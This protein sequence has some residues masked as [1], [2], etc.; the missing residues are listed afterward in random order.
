[1]DEITFL[2]EEAPVGG[3]TAQALW[4]SIFAEADDLKSLHEQIRD[5]V[6]CHFEEERAP[7]VVRLH[8]ADGR[9]VPLSAGPLPG[10]GMWADRKDMEDSADWVNKQRDAWQKR[11]LGDK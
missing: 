7:Q 5:A 2:V 4:V 1:V 6:R 8:T 10:F 3:V 9:E 11:R